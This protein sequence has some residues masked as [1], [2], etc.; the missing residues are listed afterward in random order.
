M[1]IEGL[2]PCRCRLPLEQCGL[3][4]SVLNHIQVSPNKKKHF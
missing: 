3:V 1:E 2:E 4:F